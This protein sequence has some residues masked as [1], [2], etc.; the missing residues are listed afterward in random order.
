MIAPRGDF[1]YVAVPQLQGQIDSAVNEHGGLILDAGGITFID[2]TIVT[3]ILATHLRIANLPVRLA[4]LFDIYG[5][6]RVLDIYP[7]VAGA[8]AT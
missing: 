8:R 1:D 4:R 3:L 6:D 7:T 2:S 5:I